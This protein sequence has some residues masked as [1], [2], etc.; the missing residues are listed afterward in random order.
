M[1]VCPKCQYLR[2]ASD[3]APDWQCPSCGIAYAKFQQAQG[4]GNTPRPARRPAPAVAREESGG[5]LKMLLVGGLLLGLII[6]AV[7]K[8]RHQPHVTAEAANAQQFDEAKKAFDDD[9]LDAA[10]KGFGPLADAGDAKAQYYLGRLYGL[11]WSEGFNSARHAADPKMQLK[12]FT[13]SAEQGDV[14][15][16]LALGDM[17]DRGFGETTDRGPGTHWYQ[18]AADQGDAAGQYHLALAYERGTGVTKDEAQAA[19]WYRK[20]ASQGYIEALNQLGILY[21]WGRGVTKSNFTAY[22]LIGLADAIGK[23]Q[24][25]GHAPIMAGNDLAALRKQLSQS[26]IEQADDVIANWTVAKPLPD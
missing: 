24:G 10:L 9:K 2:K 16:Q 8:V 7:W 11:S 4:S 21:A 13:K 14:P 5:A 6:F 19:A 18:L 26:E 23:R 25:Y 3:Q 22:K 20:S 17:Y 12:W 1:T 15:A